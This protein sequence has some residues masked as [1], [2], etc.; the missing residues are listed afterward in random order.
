MHLY[1]PLY[2]KNMHY[3]KPPEVDH[4]YPSMARLRIAVRAI[5]RTHGL[6][7]EKAWTHRQI[8]ILTGVLDLIRGKTK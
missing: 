8:I 6:S 3:T 5:F 7:N 4:A 2:D 1:R